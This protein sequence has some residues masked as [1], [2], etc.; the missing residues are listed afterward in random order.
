MQGVNLVL[1][2]NEKMVG[3]NMW[4]M[5]DPA[6]RFIIKDLAATAAKGGGWYKYEFSDPLTKKFGDKESYVTKVP[7]FDG[8]IGVGFYP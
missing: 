2:T 8:F 4:E 1:G 5:R 7:G 3:K 6:G